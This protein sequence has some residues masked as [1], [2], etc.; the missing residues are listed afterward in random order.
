MI[1]AFIIIIIL[2]FNIILHSYTTVMAHLLQPGADG[3]QRGDVGLEHLVPHED[4][5]LGVHQQHAP[6]LQATLPPGKTTQRKPRVQMQLDIDARQG[7][8]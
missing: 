4:L 6:R 3:P 5:L 7:R 8:V 2:T 1:I